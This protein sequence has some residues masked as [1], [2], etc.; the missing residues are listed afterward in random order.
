ME[1]ML[2][3]FAV[4]RVAFFRDAVKE[5]NHPRPLSVDVVHEMVKR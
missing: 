5:G 2:T 1:N 4:D 3:K